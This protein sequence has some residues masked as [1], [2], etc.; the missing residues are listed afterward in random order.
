MSNN[1]IDGSVLIDDLRREFDQVVINTPELRD[2]LVKLMILRR[3]THDLVSY[4]LDCEVEYR[5]VAE[6]NKLQ[7]LTYLWEF[8]LE[9]DEQLPD[10]LIRIVRLVRMIREKIDLNLLP[11]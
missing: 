10:N 4:V 1:L 2:K 11:K 5:E 6:E 7:C 3:D 9:H 8:A